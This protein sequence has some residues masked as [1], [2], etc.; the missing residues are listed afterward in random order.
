[1][2]RKHAKVKLTSMKMNGRPS[3][4]SLCGP[5]DDSAS[6]SW[7]LSGVCKSC[8]AT[9]LKGFVGY[10]VIC[11]IVYWTHSRLKTK[12]VVSAAMQT[13]RFLTLREVQ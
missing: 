8:I 12:S 11:E 5:C 6:F 7:L 3:T 13:V 10:L 1:M 2:M 9:V 4:V